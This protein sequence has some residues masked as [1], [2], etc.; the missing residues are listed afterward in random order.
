MKKILFMGTPEFS[1]PILER[2]AKDY[3]V[4]GVV[5]QPDRP[6]GR[7]RVLTPPPVKKKALELG[8][9]VY[10]P[11]KLRD[12]AEL[13]ELVELD[14]DLL[15]TAAYGQIL[16]VSLLEAPRFGS[17]NVHASLLPAYRGGAPVHYAVLDGQPETGVTIMYMVKQ[18][19]A[20]DMLAQ[21]KIPITDQDDT[22]T[23]FD[24][25]SQLGAEL[26]MDTLPE[27]F[28]GHLEAVPQDAEKVTFAR[29]ISREQEKIDWNKT[30]REVFNQVRGLSP[31]PVA[32]TTLTEKPFKI[33]QA[34]L[35][36]E[37]SADPAGSFYPLGKNRLGITAGDG[38][39]VELLEVQPA[40]K[41]K[42]PTA[43]FMQGAGRTLNEKTRFG[44]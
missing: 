2:L 13:A 3:Q 21:R 12:S 9:N 11:E 38:K 18:L 29:N 44:D 6:V 35:T 16:P 1:V 28:A 8:L 33:W 7:K 4:I 40:G 24:K 19:D 31:W 42:M 10:Q 20:G 25:L 14:M 34:K 23:M 5:T 41:P 17:I 15:V 43:S 26:L 27:L 37:T 36:E 32:Y 39:V 22:G 30:A